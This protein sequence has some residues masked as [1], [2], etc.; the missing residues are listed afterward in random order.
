[1]RRIKMDY[2]DVLELLRLLGGSIRGVTV[3]GYVREELPRPDNIFTNVQTE[4]NCTFR[5]MSCFAMDLSCCATKLKELGVS[6]T[7]VFVHGDICILSDKFKDYP[8]WY[9]VTGTLRYGSKMNSSY[10]TLLDFK[11]KGSDWF[12]ARNDLRDFDAYEV[13]P[14]TL[15]QAVIGGRGLP[16]EI[17]NL[18]AMQATQTT[19]KLDMPFDSS[20]PVS[21]SQNS[22]TVLKSTVKENRQDLKPY[23]EKAEE[24]ERYLDEAHSKLDE[25]MR[26]FKKKYSLYENNAY[27]TQ[28]LVNLKSNFKTKRTQHAFTGQALV[29]K[30]LQSYGKLAKGKYNGV[31]VIDY[32][33]SSFNDVSDY[34]L[35]GEQ[36]PFDGK[37]WTLC[38]E[39]F[40][41]QEKVYAGILGALLDIDF[42]YIVSRLNQEGISFTKLVR[43]NPY[44]LSMLGM[45]GVKDSFYL[46]VLFNRHQES[47][48]DKFRNMCLLH[49]YVMHSGNNSTLYK[50][51]QVT[52]LGVS[53]VFIPMYAND[54]I[55]TFFT[56]ERV[57]R[58][59]TDNWDTYLGKRIRL[60]SKNQLEV[61]LSDYLSCGLG[62]SLGAYFTSNAFLTQELYIY[63]RLYDDTIEPLN[64]SED[65]IDRC[66][67]EY[68]DM[69]GFKLES[70]QRQ[71]VHLCKY[72]MSCLSG[73]AGSGKTTTVGCIVYVLEK[74]CNNLR[75]DFG[76]PT[77]KAAKV[78]QSVVK[79]P[80]RTLNS[81]CRIGLDE[82]TL[83]DSDESGSS[84]SN[85]YYIFDEMSMVGVSLLYKTLRKLPHS[86]FLYVGDINQLKS[87]SKGTVFKFLLSQLPCVYL[88]VSK[89][90][91][92]NS[93][94]TY[95]S[96]VI[97]EYPDKPL[98][99]TE[100]FKFI[101]CADDSIDGAVAGIC[102]YYLGKSQ[103]NTFGLPKLK[104]DPDD[105]QVISPITK[106][107][108]RWGTYQLNKRLQSLFNFQ[109]QADDVLVLGKN[110]FIIEDRVIHTKNNS[111][112]MQWYSTYKGGTFQKIYGSGVVNGDI[113]KIKGVVN[114][115][116]VTFLDEVEDI[117][118]DFEYPSNLR[119]DSTYSGNN[120]YFV[121]VEYWDTAGER[122]FYALYRCTKKEDNSYTGADIGLIDLFYAGSTHKMQGSQSKI[123]ICCL[124]S[125]SFNGFLTRNMLYTMV[126]RGE[127]LVILVGSKSQLEKA[128]QTVECEDAYTIGNLL[129]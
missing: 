2:V 76:S 119:D 1:M 26:G 83:F 58:Y 32:L 34:I 21:S 53:D 78:L 121:V 43:E 104:V 17:E 79:K 18:P 70:E 30:Y 64:I 36:P 40:S 124:G 108:Y 106:A 128:R 101:A 99:V 44:A 49:D 67:D 51:S 91:A 88:R 71:G 3:Y 118:D 111:Y 4:D 98:K 89:R 24:F 42:T 73:S 116:T 113:G 93:G 115:K 122:P 63:K 109:R 6:S 14:D 100:D 96:N 80:V 66:I 62:V 92:E 126:T 60:L 7:V 11:R 61:A 74:L 81:L 20:I 28:L 72:P 55:P 85:T 65:D 77:G 125:V 16:P 114:S 41:D 68:E 97:N 38:E 86:R 5:R 46:G 19:S 112:G 52:G 23:N 33:L 127:K 87:I 48:L 9:M 15:V 13:F 95:N 84:S 103:L 25:L 50:L 29:K 12:I 57:L 47:S 39:A 35:Y 27:I 123:A 31:P 56:N 117:P 10:V 69:V 75:V 120:K 110:Q 45:L 107:T 90:S 82:D 59:N 102:S 8:D 129:E 37:A 105:I 22:N 94:I 54:S